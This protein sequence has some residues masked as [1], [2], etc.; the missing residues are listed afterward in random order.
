MD[1]L[2]RE[3]R[4]SELFE[5]LY[6]N[7]SQAINVYRWLKETKSEST[8]R[9]AEEVIYLLKNVSLIETDYE[10]TLDATIT[11]HGQMIHEQIGGLFE[12]LKYR[13]E[14][15]E[16]EKAIANA[17][18]EANLTALSAHEL[19]VSNAKTNKIH[20][21][22]NLVVTILL[23]LI[24]LVNLKVALELKLVASIEDLIRF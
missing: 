23:A 18:H 4:A 16:S 15:L 7:P 12:Y 5:D 11:V 8:K 3:Q 17:E 6:K 21:W 20:F 14:Q 9:N 13:E 2:E 19:N 10:L 22:I 1:P 24:G